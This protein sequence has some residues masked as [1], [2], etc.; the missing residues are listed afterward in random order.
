MEDEEG[1]RTKREDEE[2][3]INVGQKNK[4]RAT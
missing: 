1:E 2:E 4:Q 3:G